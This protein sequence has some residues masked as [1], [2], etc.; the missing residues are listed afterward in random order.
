MNG[1]LRL[2]ASERLKLSKS[3][4]WLLVPLSPLISL[5]IGLLVSLDT[6][7]PSWEHGNYALLVTAMASFHALLFLPILTGIFSAFVCRYEHSG[8]GWKQLLTLPISRTALYFA[9]FIAVATLLSITQL[10]FLGA[11]ILAG[12]YQGINGSI[13]WG[14]LLTGVSGGL[15][16][17][18]PL[19]ALQLLVS[20]G[21]SSFAAPLVINVALTVPNL[22]IIN[23]VKFGPFYPWAQPM[24]AM[25][26]YGGEDF[27][28][29]ALPLE[30]ILI[31]VAGS[32]VVF[33]A[34]GLVYFNRKEV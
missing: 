10:L 31:T 13:P 8:G 32:F 15:L 14:M 20:A 18:L 21:W 28:G 12:A 34:A 2:V 33:L 23:S 27:G 24:R 3:F 1:F 4:I 30:N 7:E 25:L 19:A 29:F 11:V 6:F 16:A 22:L 17:C 5:A 26:V 9:K